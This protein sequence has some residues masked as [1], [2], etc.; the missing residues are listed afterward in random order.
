[1]LPPLSQSL[2][3]LLPGADRGSG[4]LVAGH[5]TARAAQESGGRGG[6]RVVSVGNRGLQ[7]L[8]AAAA[9]LCCIRLPILK[10]L[11]CAH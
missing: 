11:L 9:E 8:Q 4:H 10:Q 6:T 5:V 2:G 7:L 3:F 1:M